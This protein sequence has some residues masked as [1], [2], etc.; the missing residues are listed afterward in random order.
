MGFYRV[1]TV[2]HGFLLEDDNFTIIDFPGAFAT[3]AVGID[4]AGV[5]VGGYFDGKAERGYMASPEEA[6]DT[7]P[8]P[9]PPP[10]SGK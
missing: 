4:D 3:G 7:A 9:E 5:I 10:E 2:V 1:G 6:A 8:P